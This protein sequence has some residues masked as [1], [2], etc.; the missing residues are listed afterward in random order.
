M[1]RRKEEKGRRESGGRRGEGI[2]SIQLSKSS[3]V[4]TIDWEFKE[5]LEANK[6]YS[7]VQRRGGGGKE[8]GDTKGGDR[9]GLRK[10]GWEGKRGGGRGRKR[11]DP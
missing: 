4:K 3:E 5:N 7:S 11:P 1:G 8:G 9:E 6:V 10:K 2:F